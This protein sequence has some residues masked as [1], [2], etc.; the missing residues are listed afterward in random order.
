MFTLLFFLFAPSGPLDVPN[1]I[2]IVWLSVLLLTFLLT[3]LSLLFPERT[4]LS[5]SIFEF[6]FFFD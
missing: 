4:K 1:F 2:W 3:P 6:L 5:L